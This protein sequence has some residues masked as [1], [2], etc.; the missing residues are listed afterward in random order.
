M[1]ALIGANLFAISLP[2]CTV[3]LSDIVE[4][5]SSP[6]LAGLSE[7]LPI[8]GAPFAQELS[9]FLGVFVRHLTSRKRRLWSGDHN[10]GGLA[11]R[12]TKSPFP[13]TVVAWHQHA[14]MHSHI[15]GRTFRAGNTGL[16]GRLHV[17]GYPRGRWR[18]SRAGPR[19]IEGAGGRLSKSALRRS[20]VSPAPSC[21][22]GACC[23]TLKVKNPDS[24]AMRRAGEHFAR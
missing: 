17:A 6:L 21:A 23:E 2:I 4:I 8:G 14:E 20:S 3:C 18:M 19:L 16:G 15:A 11:D 13:A 12:A 24:P 7:L 1:L 10:T 9:A 5:C 22:A